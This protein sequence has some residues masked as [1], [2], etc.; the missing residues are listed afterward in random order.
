MFRK[1][2]SAPGTGSREFRSPIAARVVQ[3]QPELVLEAMK[4][5][6]VVP[7]PPGTRVA[8]WRVA[9]GDSV[10]EGQL[11]ALVEPA[12]AAHAAE[13]AQE[14]PDRDAIRPDLQRVIDRHA[15]TLDENRKEAVAK[16]HAQG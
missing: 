4:A 6:H 10:D 5:E 16:R 13:A 2:P 1:T 12:D 11:L 3:L 15:F 7:I 9:A 8:E 14:T